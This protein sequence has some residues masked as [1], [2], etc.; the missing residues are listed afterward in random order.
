M[1]EFGGMELLAECVSLN[2]PL[3]DR[4]PEEKGHLLAILGNLYTSN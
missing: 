1:G 2:G 4:F 3:D